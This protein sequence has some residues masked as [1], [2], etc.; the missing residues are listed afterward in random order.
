MSYKYVDTA[1]LAVPCWSRSISYL[2]SVICGKLLGLGDL[3]C[4]TLRSPYPRQLIIIKALETSTTPP[5]WGSYRR[6]AARL[7]GV[8]QHIRNVIGWKCQNPPKRQPAPPAGASL[9][10]SPLTADLA[11]SCNLLWNLCVYPHQTNRRCP[12]LA[13]QPASASP[14]RTSDL[15]SAIVS[16]RS[17]PLLSPIAHLQAPAETTARLRAS[18][19]SCLSVAACQMRCVRPEWGSCGAGRLLHVGRGKIAILGL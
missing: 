6:I 18:K 14:K 10:V 2:H 9:A 13:L 17:L 16:R 1:R 11:P 12:L 19:K 15:V 7:S 8:C 4:L 3:R 5:Y